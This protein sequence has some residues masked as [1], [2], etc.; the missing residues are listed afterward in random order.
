MSSNIIKADN[1]ASSGITGI[2]QTAGSDGTLLLQTT[3]S[4]GTATTAL[5]LN[6]SQQATFANTI[7]VPNTFGFK[8]RIINGSMVISQY[9]GTSSVTPS[10][11]TY[12]IDRFRSGASQTSKL[13]WQQNAGSVTPPA[14][15]T[16]YI[17]VKPNATVSLGSGDYF[18]MLQRIEGFNVADFGWGTAN[19]KTVTLSFWV[20]SNVTG[21]FGGS[22]ENGSETRSYPYSYTISAAN[23]WQYVT[24][25]IPG[26]TSG[27]WATDNTKGISINWN[28]G[29]GSTYT[30]TAGS[31]ASAQ[32]FAPTGVTSIM[33]STSNYM[34]FTGVQIEVGTQATSFD[35]RPYGTELALCQRYYETSFTQGTSPQN[36]LGG[37]F[38]SGYQGWVAFSTTDIRSNFVY[39]AVLKRTAPVVTLYNSSTI[40]NAGNW[41]YYNSGTWYSASSSV[42]DT[43]QTNAFGVRGT[44]SFTSGYSYLLNGNWAASAEL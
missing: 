22:L 7:N 2:V 33:G 19:A 36:G 15:F 23:T 34:Y 31:W 21:L 42:T 26:D 8:N 16:N 37:L 28:F 39:F 25:T 40:S 30:G 5:T 38:N 9:N 4:G 35:Y 17:G 18:Q 6:N 24:I 27:T 11:D 12:F 29:C 10:G 44:G 20:Y 32:Y 41:G 3:T 13:T 14:G 43:T 1:G